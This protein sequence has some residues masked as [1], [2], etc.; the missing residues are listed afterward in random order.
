MS[1]EHFRIKVNW[2]FFDVDIIYFPGDGLELSTVNQYSIADV[3]DVDSLVGMIRYIGHAF[4]IFA[5]MKDFVFV[6]NFIL[7]Y[8]KDKR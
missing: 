3:F 8:I 5:Q 6:Y 2:L 4:Y 7:S 1:V